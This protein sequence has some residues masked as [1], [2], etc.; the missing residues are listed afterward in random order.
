MD[1]HDMS[2]TLVRIPNE[3]IKR[4]DYFSKKM[5]L[6]RQKLVANLL[7][8]EC[9]DLALADKVGL[10]RLGRAV[11]DLREKMSEMDYSGEKQHI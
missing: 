3:T 8:C 5:G 1:G 6:S 2:H 4:L 11:A 7:E 10:L 9:D